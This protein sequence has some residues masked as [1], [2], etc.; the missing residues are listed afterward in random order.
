MACS[1]QPGVA[2]FL[3]FIEQTS[4][5]RIT[6]SEWHTIRQL[7]AEDSGLSLSRKKVGEEHLAEGMQALAHSIYLDEGVDFADG[8]SAG[9]FHASYD[10]LQES[11][12]GVGVTEGTDRALAYLSRNGV[13]TVLA[14]VRGEED[15]TSHPH[16]H[17]NP[18]LIEAMQLWR[19]ETRA[20]NE[21]A[22]I[23]EWSTY[24]LG[25]E[26]GI[27]RELDPALGRVM[28]DVQAREDEPGYHVAIS[29]ATWMGD[30]EGDEIDTLERRTFPTII[31][32][33]NW[34]DEWEVNSV[35]EA[36]TEQ[37]WRADTSDRTQPPF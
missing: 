9:S 5:E 35:K 11:L 6:Q 3:D 29:R 28:A 22:A 25:N 16:V 1:R 17:N 8:Q 14:G 15:G 7:A 26:T 10:S 31:A 24:D 34:V 37:R 18:A 36:Q 19:E 12:K 2:P 32:A 20:E 13:R 27:E 33:R 30:D 4:G 21:D 23:G